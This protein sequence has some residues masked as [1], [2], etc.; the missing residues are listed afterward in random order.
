MANALQRMWSS[1][2]A[3]AAGEGQY[4]PG[5]YVLP[6]TGGIL[7]N[8]WGQYANWWQLG[9]NPLYVGSRSAIVQ[10]CVSAYSQT[11]AM[12]PGDH[13][14][15][16]NKGGRD[17]VTTSALS[18]ILRHPNDYESI[19][20]FLLNAVR[21]LY[22]DGNAYAYC[23]RN[24]R[25][26][27]DTMH[28]MDPRSS[29]AHVAPGGEVFYNLRGNIVVDEM[30]GPLPPIPQRDVLHIKLHTIPHNPLLGESPL[31]SAAPEICA[32]D[33][34][35]QQQLKFFLNQAR[36]S[37]VL[38]TDL[39]LDKDQVAAARQRWDEQTK[40]EGTGGTP[41]LTAGLKPFPITMTAKDAQ[42]AEVIKAS[43]QDIALAFRIPLQVLGL[44]G[45]SITST[46]ALM[47]L[48]IAS[49]LGF[50]LNHVEE[51][52]GLTFELKGQPDDYIEFDTAALLRSMF[53]DRVTAL[54]EGVLGGIFAR[55][56][57][58]NMEGLDDKPGG[59]EPR[60]QQ[61]QVPLTAANAI[62]SPGAPG[63]ITIPPA[64]KPAPSAPAAPG[65]SPGSKTDGKSI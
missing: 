50:C 34:I 19:S 23:T 2:V 45:G 6:I 28:L 9:Y 59:D 56:E 61:Q 27:I 13:W 49:G 65:P 55:K 20:D 52:F 15:S 38:S 31:M 60:V 54:K 44:G 37:F 62:P 29:R 3:K 64:S 35:K 11:V 43:D 1:L 33:A 39:Q 17:R 46:E 32:N 47:Q 10:A 63:K 22:L 5:P 8:D 7:P 30:L 51:A 4:R 18:R 41:I 14:N 16:N 57:A 26:E 25:Y 24:S 12:L 21:D 58:R 36:P 48:W 40:G 42:L 53:K